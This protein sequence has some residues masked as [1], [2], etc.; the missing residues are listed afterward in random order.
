MLLDIRIYKDN[1][2][3]IILEVRIILVLFSHK[4][5]MDHMRKLHSKC[6]KEDESLEKCN[7]VECQNIIHLGCFKNLVAK[8]GEDEWEGPLFCG[9]CC[10]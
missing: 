3:L 5:Q 6:L 8:F 9:K 7:N 10:F 1:G 4:L 2:V